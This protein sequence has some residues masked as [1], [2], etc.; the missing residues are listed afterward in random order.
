MLIYKTRDANAAADLKRH[1]LTNCMNNACTELGVNPKEFREWL[2]ANNAMYKML[3]LRVQDA[4]EEL[5][6]GQKP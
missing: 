4:M 2:Q 3:Q 6:N 1:I 5:K